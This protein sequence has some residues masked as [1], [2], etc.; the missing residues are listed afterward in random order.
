MEIHAFYAHK[1]YQIVK[2]AQTIPFVNNA[3]AQQYMT[4]II[5]VIIALLEI[6]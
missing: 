3:L 2:N 5:L 4:K 1:V 6:M